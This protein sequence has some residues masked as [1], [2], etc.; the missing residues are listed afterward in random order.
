[1]FDIFGVPIA[2]LLPQLT[3]GLVNGSF[4]ALLSLGLAIIF[5]LL[6]LV[7][8]AHGAL[9]MMGAMVAWMLFNYLGIGYWWALALAPLIVAAFGI[10]LERTIIR[11]TYDMDHMYGM[12]LTFGLTLM[13]TS[14]FRY[15]YG[16]SG[17]PYDV[18]EV[19]SGAYDLGFM[20]MPKYRAWVI[21]CSLIVCFGTWYVIERTR[22]G[23][24][25]R[26][27]TEN[28]ALTQAFGINVPRIVTLA[29]AFGVSLAALGGV[30]AAPILQVSPL[31]GDLVL[32]STFAVVVIGGFGSIF[33]AI[34]T[35]LGIGLVEA[36][37]KVYWAE[38]SG[39]VV[40]VIMLA[41]LALRPAGLFG[42]EA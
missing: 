36:L 39:T 20:M 30:L 26:A 38:A 27:A 7:N 29:Y 16:V 9:Y 34:V 40:F 14:A 17:M 33:G 8:F 31:M 41:V 37:A 13:I 1:M 15:F 19:F 10:L 2:A 18:P 35:G 32:I 24:Y 42:K 25:L 28:P 21:V 12:L 22:L 5:G 4:Y 11:R 23:G 3:V 6:G